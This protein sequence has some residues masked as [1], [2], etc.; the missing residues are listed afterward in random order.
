MRAPLLLVFALSLPAVA[1]DALRHWAPAHRTAQREYEQRLVAAVDGGSLRR[2]HDL[3]ASRP[4]RAGSA[5]DLAVAANLARVFRDLGLEVEEHEIWVYLATPVEGAVEIVAPERLALPV[6]EEPVDA[7]SGHP[8]GSIGWNA[9]SGSGEV[10]AGVVYANYGTK[11]DFEKLDELGIDVKGRVVVARYGKNFRGYKAK[12]AEARGAAGLVIYT[13]PYDSGYFKGLMYPEGGY[14]NGSSIQR[15][16]ILTL[17]YRGDPLTPFRPATRDA[18]RLDPAQVAFPKIPVQPVGWK[19]AREILSRME[20]PPVPEGWQGALPFAYRLAGGDRLQVRVKVVQERKLTRTVNVV[21]T[22]KGSRQP[23]ELVVVGAHHDAWGFGAGDP[24]AGTILVLESARCFAEAARAGLRPA[25]SLCF[26]G[27]AAE[28]YGLMGSTEWVEAHRERLARDGV[29]YLNL[30]MSAMGPDPR[31]SA[32]PSLRRVIAGACRDEGKELKQFGNLGGGSDHMGFYCHLAIPAAGLGAG[33]SKGVS[34]HSLYDNLAWYRK[35]V[36]E[37]YAP[38]RTLTRIVNRILAR[39]ANGD[40]LPLDPVRYGTD[41]RRHLE[42]LAGRAA[43]LE[44]EADFKPLDTL[45]RIY[46]SR[47]RYVRAELLD[48]L[49]QGRVQLAQANRVLLRM[50]RAWHFPGGLPGRPWFRNLYAASDEDSGYAAWMLPGLRHAVEHRDA[51]ALAA[52]LRRYEEVLYR[53]GRRLDRLAEL[54]R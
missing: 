31:S 41:M 39:L 10:T 2:Y 35:V 42:A 34:Y 48:A 20:G 6:R 5:G 4:H 50:E 8:E 53:L 23:E 18:A 32:A 38:A 11:Q 49:D 47:A 44:F 17:P 51:D 40:L 33:G 29:A 45:C 36:G 25:R 15:G 16:S 27:W 37:D 19:A 7:F 26:A 12:F 9:F 54:A 22:L 1:D 21:G 3:L 52:M 46:E 43:E 28:E 13:D 24:T 14:A 30:D